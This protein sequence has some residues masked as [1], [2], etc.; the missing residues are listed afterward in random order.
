MNVLIHGSGRATRCAE[1][2]WELP[3]Q[4]HADGT[5]TIRAR[6]RLASAG[7]GPLLVLEHPEGE[8][9]SLLLRCMGADATLAEWERRQ[10]YARDARPGELA[11]ECVLATGPP[12]AMLEIQRR[13]HEQ[14]RAQDPSLPPFAP[15]AAAVRGLM[16]MGIPVCLLSSAEEV[17]VLIRI[18]GPHVELLVDGVL[19]DEEWPAGPFQPGSKIL[20][21]DA[22]Q[23]VEIWPGVLEDESIATLSGGARAVMEREKEIFGP[24]RPLGQYWAPNGHN[25]W[26]GDAMLTAD[27]ERLHVFWLTDR[28]LHG[29][30]YGCGGCSFAHA[31]TTDLRAWQFHP[32]AYPLTEYWEAANGTG[33]M[34]VHEG[35][36]HL[37][38]NV[39][40]ERLGLEETHP[41]GPHLAISRDGINYEKQGRVNLPGEPGIIRDEQGVYHAISVSRHADG[42]WRSTR[43]ESADLREWRVAD[44]EFL[45]APGWPPSRTVFSSECFNWFRLGDW[46]Y[47]IGGRTGFWRARRA[48]G[49]YRAVGEADGPQWDIYDGLMVPQVAVWNGRAIMAG[50]LALNDHDWGGHVVFRELRQRPDGNL[51]LRRLPELEPREPAGRIRMPIDLRDGRGQFSLRIGGTLDDAEGLELRLDP[52]ARTAQW[53]TPRAGGRADDAT[54]MPFEAG[55]FAILNVEGLDEPFALDIVLHWD[56]KSDSTIIDAQIGERRTM[57]TRRAGRIAAVI[58]H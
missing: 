25:A 32:L 36:H 42:V 52:P 58:G 44:A 26:A 18:A 55:D 23:A 45:P 6:V 56:E 3:A 15:D 20:V 57:V 24:R 51:E 5:A 17:D 16:R 35:V 41:N 1:G 53:R 19:V 39:L 2:A 21:A 12:T 43:Y 40:S 31:S 37:F 4:W 29:S 11:L 9:S 48:L 8:T 49:P 38:A 54:A 13:R 27:G 7:T 34:V 22:V 30:K 28:R 10:N 47:I 50:W 14:R 46:Y 33:C